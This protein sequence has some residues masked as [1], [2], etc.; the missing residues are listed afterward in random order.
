MHMAIVGQQS[1]P[2]LAYETP[3]QDIIN[4]G[5]EEFNRKNYHESIAQ[6]NIALGNTRQLTLIKDHAPSD[7]LTLW[8]RSAAYVLLGKYRIPHFTKKLT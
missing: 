7:P 4:L 5:N 1:M 6:Y 8:N 3:V 2:S